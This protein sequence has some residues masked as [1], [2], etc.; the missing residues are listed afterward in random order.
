MEQTLKK[1]RKEF[2]KTGL[3][4]LSDNELPSLVSLVTGETVKGS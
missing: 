4:L 1:V 3:L 2:E